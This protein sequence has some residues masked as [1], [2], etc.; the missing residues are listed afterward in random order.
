[1]SSNYDYDAIIIGAG[2]SG[3]VCGCYLAKAGMKTL[4]VEKNAKPGGY[5]TSFTRGGFHFDACVYFLSGFR[6]GGTFYKIIN[7]LKLNEKLE[8]IKYPIPD[9][10]ITPNHKINLY[11]DVDKTIYEFQSNFP[12]EKIKI[13]D[14]FKN[15]TSSTSSLIKLK[16]KTFKG[17]VDSYFDDPELKTILFIPMMGYTG[18]PP[19]QLSALAACLVYKEFIFDGGYYPKGGMQSFADIFLKNFCENGGDMILDRKV[20]KISV[21]DNKVESIILED[22]RSISGRYLI[23]ACDAYETFFELIG[24]QDIPQTIRDKINNMQTSL[25]AFLVYL[26]INKNLREISEL[27]SHTW[28]IARNYNDI[29]RIYTNLFRGVYDYLAISSSSIK[30]NLSP[31]GKESIF[32]FINMPFFNKEF[33]SRENRNKISDDLL[34]IAEYLIPDISKH[35]EQMITATPNTLLKWTLNFKGAAYG[36]AATVPQFGDYEFSEKTKIEGLY[37]VGHWTN[38][39]GG[40]ISVANSGYLTAK[41]ILSHI[42]N[43]K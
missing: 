17:M 3:L 21:R 20:K 18:L 7:D 36:Y 25:S 42:K 41:R 32:L 8:L 22:D 24:Q 28:I 27:K 11:S 29:E 5:C 12:K 15:I 23:A 43:N 1:M 2:I 10:V 19:S 39:G 40:V 14:F 13:H 35:I 9:V 37:R 26:G 34:K 38:R 16:N 33:W 30:N 31:A 6:K 4:I